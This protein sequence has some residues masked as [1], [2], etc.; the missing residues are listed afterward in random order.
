VER[1]DVPEPD[2]GEQVTLV[3]PVDLGLRAGDDLE[4]AVQ[5]GQR[6]L[7][8][9][10]EFGRELGGDPGPRLGDEHL[11]P[12]VV[13]GEPVLGDQPLMDHAGLERDVGPQPR[14]DHADER[15]DQLRLGAGPRRPG[16]G[17]RGCVLGQVLPHRAPIDPALTG[18]LGIACARGMQ[19]AET[20]NI[21]PGLRIQDHEQGHPSDSSTWQLTNRR[22]TQL[23]ASRDSTR[24]DR[25]YTSGRSENDT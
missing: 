12:L 4:A 15:G 18:D 19:G 21:H 7:V 20:T 6:V 14:L 22:V 17:D 5:P 11:D 8:L 13:A 24:R 2:V 10:G 25:T 1:V 9:R 16:R 23:K 3:A